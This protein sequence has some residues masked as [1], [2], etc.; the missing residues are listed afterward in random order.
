[1]NWIIFF[2]G[3]AVGFVVALIWKARQE[4]S[5]G[6]FTE[7]VIDDIKVT[8]GDLSLEALQKF[9]VMA[10]SK[11][12]DE[13][14]LGAKDLD[15]KKGL[16]DQ[17]LKTMTGE[18]E[19]VSRLME[20]LEKDREQK[21]GELSNQL[22]NTGEQTGKLTE[23][24][25]KLRE[26]LASDKTRGQWGERMAEDILRMA[27]FIEDVNYIKQ[28]SINEDRS[29][30][31]FTFLLPRDLKVNMDVK[32]P[33]SNYVRYVE[34][35]PESKTDRDKFLEKFL[36]DVKSRVKEVAT[37]DYINPEQNT[38]DYVLMFIPNEQ[39]YS[40]I[41]EQ[42]SSILDNAL[43]NR[44]VICSPITLFAVLAIIRQ[45]VDNFSFAERSN[46]I[47]SQ[48]GTFKVQWRK[49]IETLKV[50]ENRLQGVQKT[51]DELTSTRKRK[52]E[53]SVD[54]LD[55]I[56]AQRELPVAPDESVEGFKT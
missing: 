27:G 49:F 39:I 56:R 35:D 29:R 48:V 31:D 53:Q 3:L 22:K 20:Q 24:T 21:F 45:A 6:Y 4:K 44:V 13:R 30:P 43:M 47:L 8:F 50:L 46:E 36:K 15:T 11:L 19:R 40:F 16:I 54:K 32:F 2:A 52:L 10:D 51:F 42:D 7:K 25:G 9:I 41:H 33:Y 23:V 34:A 12:K 5:A 55:S 37:R 17:Q 14:E 26:S 1:M 18:L 28:K 38:V